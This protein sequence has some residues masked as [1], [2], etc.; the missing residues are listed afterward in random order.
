MKADFNKFD[1]FVELKMVAIYSSSISAIFWLVVYLPQ[2]I[3]NHFLITN[4]HG[5]LVDFQQNYFVTDDKKVYILLEKPKLDDSL[6][7]L[8]YNTTVSLK[9]FIHDIVEIPINNHIHVN[10]KIDETRPA[11]NIIDIIKKIPHKNQLPAN[12]SRKLQE[13]YEFGANR[14][15]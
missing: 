5:N 6:L 7:V 2:K 8:M 10:F 3:N 14:R 11:K 12:I 1:F 15:I 9:V 4:Y 13:K